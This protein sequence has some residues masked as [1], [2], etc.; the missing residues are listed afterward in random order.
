MPAFKCTQVR[1]YYIIPPNYGW[2]ERFE[3]C[4]ASADA[5]SAFDWGH[6]NLAVADLSGP[7]GDG[8][9]FHN[10]V[11][12]LA[13]D[14]NLEAQLGKEIHLVLGAALDFH[15][16]LLPHVA[17]DFGHGH[18]MNANS[19]KSLTHLVEFEW[20]DDSNDELHGLSCPR[21]TAPRKRALCGNENPL[22]AGSFAQTT[23]RWLRN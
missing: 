23:D 2:L 7:G 21:R 18:S 22:G 20:L 13:R 9:H 14:C 8:E 4:L 15:M 11:E 6:E 12:L 10:L 3:V 19:G 17:F 16:A 5:H 1:L